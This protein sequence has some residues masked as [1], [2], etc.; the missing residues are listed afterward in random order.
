MMLGLDNN[1]QIHTKI[2]DKIALLILFHVWG[3]YDFKHFVLVT[4]GSIS[5]TKGHLEAMGPKNCVL[6]YVGS[7]M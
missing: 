4:N 3:M 1:I 5:C 6:L 2:T 7:Q